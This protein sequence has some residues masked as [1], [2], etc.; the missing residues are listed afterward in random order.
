LK[1]IR[2]AL[3]HL[4]DGGGWIVNITGL[5]AEMPTAGVAAYSAV[6]AGLSAAST[7]IARE[8]RRSGIHLLDAR[9]PHT[10]TGLATRPIEGA[11]P[12]MKPGLDPDLV[13]ATIVA[14]LEAG[15]RELAAADFAAT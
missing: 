8:A 3:P 6:K 1:A 10:E 5:V 13:A 2:A 4:T 12:P 7:A 14:G 9:P 11:A 15:K